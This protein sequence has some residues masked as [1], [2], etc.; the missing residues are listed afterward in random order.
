MMKSYQPSRTIVTFNIAGFQFW[1]GADVL[2]ELK[3]GTRLTLAPEFD[4]PHDP[5][6]LAL[7]YG[8]TKLGFVPAEHNELAATMVYYG[9]SEVFEFVVL[10]V[11]P[12]NSPWN[13]VRVALR[14]RDNR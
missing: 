14:V 11:A 13:Q 2:A 3:P 6:A 10:Q 5:N 4:N 8:H 12:E 1:D 7:Y 9:H